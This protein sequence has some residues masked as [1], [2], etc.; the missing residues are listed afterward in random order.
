VYAN[1]SFGVA[2]T[3]NTAAATAD[4][5]AVTSGVYA[6]AAYGTANTA[7]QKASSSGSYANSAFGVANTANT[8]AVTADQRAVTS[9]DYANS[10]FGASNSASSYANSAY[11][12]ANNSLNVESGGTITGDLTVNGNISVTGC[13]VTF[14]VSTFRTT[15]HII[16]IGHGTT[17]VPTQNAGIRL[18]RGDENP[19][20]IR[21]VEPDDK[22][23]FT[24]DGTNYLRFAAD[25]GEVY[26]NAAFST[27]NS[28]SSYANAAFAA[29]NTGGSGTDSW[30]RSAANSASSYANAAFAAANTGGGGGGGTGQYASTMK[31]DSFTGTG[32]C[33]QFTLTQEP[34]GEDYTIVS[35]NGIL[36]HKSAYSLSGSIVTF[37]EAPENNIAIDIVSLVNKVAGGSSEIVVDNFT[38]TGACTQFTLTTTPANENFVT[39]VFDGVTQSRLTYS[40]SGT[41]ITF[42][43]APPNT[44]NIEITTIKNIFGT[45]I[46]RNYLGDGSNTNFTVTSGVSA[47]S[48]LVFQNGIAQRPI[49]D[50][51][52]SGS[53]LSF[54]TAPTNGEIVQ[55]RE[56]VGDPGGSTV[57]AQAAFDKANTAA[58]TGKSIAMAIVFGG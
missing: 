18:L 42:D 35:L 26:A 48:V 55:V 24:N 1:S 46:N 16:D 43:E 51:T 41:T 34:S 3:A 27:A 49:T 32:A 58:T 11:A 19:V 29:A 30:A 44:A 5:R 56:L 40:V 20:Q 6:N 15:D 23:E 21:W 53:T 47:N 54:S 10:A 50:Y 25:S 13:T 2:N 45:F 28:A 8:N 33:T 9:G 36:Q 4:Q 12:R 31:V 7:D 57:L 52:V 39:A 37:S 22:W 14:T 17:G 38:G